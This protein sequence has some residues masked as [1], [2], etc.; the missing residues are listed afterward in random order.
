MTIDEQLDFARRRIAT[1]RATPSAVGQERVNFNV[2]APGDIAAMPLVGATP[3][4]LPG[5]QVLTTAGLRRLLAS[6]S[7]PRVIEVSSVTGDRIPTIPGAVWLDKAGMGGWAATG[8]G[9][10]AE[11]FRAAMARLVPD[12]AA[13]VVFTCYAVNC[14]QA[15]RA[16]HRAIALG[17]S[18]VAW[19]RGGTQAWISAGLPVAQALLETAIYDRGQESELLDRQDDEL[20]RLASPERG[21]RPL[22]VARWQA[23]LVA[24]HNREPVFHQAIN[25]IHSLLT[26]AGVKREDI[27]WLSAA[28]REESRWPTRANLE[29]MFAS[30]TMGPRDGCFVYVTSHGDENG[31]EVITGRDKYSLAPAELGRMLDRRC[32]AA[33]TIV[34]VSA[35]HAGVYA[36]PTVLRRNRIVL[37]AARRDRTSFGC[38]SDY[39]FSF[40]D[41]CFIR[42]FGEARNW[43]DLALRINGCVRERETEARF[44]PRSLPTAS[45]G[46]EARAVSMISIAPARAPRPRPKPEPAAAPTEG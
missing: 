32:G 33:P 34:I 43:P 46:T 21:V 42:N 24:A 36:D 38:S 5:G 40:Y 25:R 2:A 31:V 13:P 4:S 29:A 37:T 15:Y 39:E 7:P 6:A 30:S 19:Y 3:T 20:R 11:Q 35:C 18:G 17:H 8:P 10:E 9:V 23:M 26:R 45:I 22:R 27:E 1:A 41:A 28:V 14:W 12:T 44:A 16:A